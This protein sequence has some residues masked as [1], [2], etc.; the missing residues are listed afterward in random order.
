MSQTAAVDNSLV[1]SIREI[2]FQ[3]GLAGARAVF[4]LPE[5][6]RVLPVEA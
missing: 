3:I 1:F 5:A 4:D 2:R 6:K